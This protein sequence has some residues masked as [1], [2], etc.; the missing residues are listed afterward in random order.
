MLIE[1]AVAAAAAGG[2]APQL[3]LG[4]VLLD[5]SVEAAARYFEGNCCAV[6]SD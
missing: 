3:Q 2:F 6:G 4:R 5:A 1:G